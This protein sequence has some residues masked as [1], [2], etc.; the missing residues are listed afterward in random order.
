[1]DGQAITIVHE[2]QHEK[3]QIDQHEPKQTKDCNQVFPSKPRI[4]IR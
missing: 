3:L 1:M 4:V 2:T